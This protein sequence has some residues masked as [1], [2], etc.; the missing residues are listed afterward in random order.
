MLR[1]IE[2][3]KLDVFLPIH[4][5]FDNFECTLLE[6]PLMFASNDPHF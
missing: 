6:D 2:P 1:N 3:R 4:E 5:T